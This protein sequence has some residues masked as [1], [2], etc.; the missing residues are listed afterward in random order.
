MITG[1]TDIL[2]VAVNVMP[3]DDRDTLA[4]RI[5]EVEHQILPRTVDLYAKGRLKIEGRKVMRDLKDL[6]DVADGKRQLT[7]KDQASQM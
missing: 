7:S 5:L 6:K 3:G 1:V 2:Q 4:N